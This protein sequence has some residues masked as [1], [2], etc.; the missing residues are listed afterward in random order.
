M[1]RVY[2]ATNAARICIKYLSRV[3]F[4]AV[5]PNR[6]WTSFEAMQEWVAV[7]PHYKVNMI[8]YDVCS[9]LQLGTRR[10]S[11]AGNARE[12]RTCPRVYRDLARR[13]RTFERMHVSL[14]RSSLLGASCCCCHN[15]R[16]SLPCVKNKSHFSFFVC[17]SKI[18]TLPHSCAFHHVWGKFPLRPCETLCDLHT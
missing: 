11:G 10:V 14:G 16:L 4:T 7:K 18:L 1:Q 9:D 3:S 6:V 2:D 5:K 15:G 12:N 8:S 13:V 17:S